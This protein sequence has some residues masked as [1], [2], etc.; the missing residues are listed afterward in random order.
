MRLSNRSDDADTA[1]RQ[2]TENARRSPT[3]TR[4]IRNSVCPQTHQHAA[5][6]AAY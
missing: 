1:V 2:P 5:G 6:R 3:D 4:P